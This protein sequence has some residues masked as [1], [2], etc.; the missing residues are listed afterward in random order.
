ME[1]SDRLI[2]EI[3]GNSLVKR[4]RE[5]KANSDRAFIQMSKKIGK[6]MGVYFILIPN[7]DGAC[8]ELM[9]MRE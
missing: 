1:H 9:K 4:L 5:Y 8:Y 3:F 6:E 2:S 7:S